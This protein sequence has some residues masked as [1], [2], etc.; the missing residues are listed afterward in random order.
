[1]ALLGTRLPD[2][3][4]LRSSGD[5]RGPVKALGYRDGA[6]VRRDASMCLG[7]LR[8]PRLRSLPWRR[9]PVPRR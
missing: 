9:L 2:V 7:T 5:I 1:M 3:V 4:R 8:D 6:R